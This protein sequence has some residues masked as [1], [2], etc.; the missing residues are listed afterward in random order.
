LKIVLGLVV[1]A[2]ILMIGY[3]V[4]YSI[5]SKSDNNFSDQNVSTSNPATTTT[6]SKGSGN[7]LVL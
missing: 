2:I 5:Y 7:L 6:E 1:F 3:A 4:A